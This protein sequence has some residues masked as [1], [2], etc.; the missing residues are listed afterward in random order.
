MCVLNFTKMKNVSKRM[1]ILLVVVLTVRS[2]S[3]QIKS[4]DDTG[5]KKVNGVEYKIVKNVPGENVKLGD[6]LQFHQ[7]LYVDT[8]VT[9]DS[10]ASGFIGSHCHKAE[11]WE[12][13]TEYTRAGGDTTETE[14]RTEYAYA[15]FDAILPF[16]SIGDSAIAQVA[17]DTLLSGEGHEFDEDSQSPYKGIMLKTSIVVVGFKSRDTYMKERKA[18]MD[19]AV[20]RSEEAVLGMQREEEER[21]ARAMHEGD[22]M[23]QQFFAAHKIQPR[24]TASGKF[25]IIE[26]KGIG[27]AIKE[28]DSVILKYTTSTLDGKIRVPG[29]SRE[30]AIKVGEAELGRD[31][32]EVLTLMQKGGEAIFYLPSSLVSDEVPKCVLK[33]SMKVVDEKMDDTLEAAKKGGNTVLQNKQHSDIKERESEKEAREKSHFEQM[34]L[35]ERFA[36]VMFENDGLLQASFA[37]RKIHPKKAD[38]GLYYILGKRGI[39]PNI[40]EG[41]VVMLKFTASTLDGKILEPKI[42][43]KG[44]KEV[45]VGQSEQLWPG[46]NEVLTMMQK[47]SEAVLYLP[48]K[49]VDGN[50]PNTVVKVSM[51]VLDVKADDKLK[52]SEKGDITVNDKGF[53]KVNG[54]EYKIVRDI[55]GK[56]A[57]EGESVDVHLFLSADTI[58]LSDTRV[59][60]ATVRLGIENVIDRGDWKAILPYLSTGDS[61]IANVSYDTLLFGWRERIPIEMREELPIQLPSWYKKGM[62]FHVSMTIVAI[63]SVNEVMKE[64]EEKSAENEREKQEAAARQMPEDDKI[65]QIYFIKNKIHPLK[66]ASG[67]YYTIEKKGTG[68]NIVNGQIV[69]IR[70]I[71]SVLNGL[72][73]DSNMDHTKEV[74]KITKGERQLIPGL[75]DALTLM[76]NG[77]EAIFYLPS[78][79]AYGSESPSNDIPPNSIM[80]FY[81]KVVDVQESKASR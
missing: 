16:L 70:Y 7:L 59:K 79:L 47:G 75:E 56:N 4:P 72:I 8:V 64:M 76:Q 23:L 51:K 53:K 26:K 61:V 50:L 20:R 6:Y 13:I 30:R 1:S 69:S 17:Y 48:S 65:L 80:R 57:E 24:K 22:A 63:K 10:R 34:F 77:S 49:F 41:Q 81:L 68:P 66:T 36:W 31:Y 32:Y 35:Q 9:D 37:E 78:P 29:T 62:T 3:A 46:I 67:L 54:V 43:M 18:I 2:S 40:R 38:A 5:F 19:D 11:P 60:G 33:T 39:G 55:P 12:F 14:I 58:V 42:N 27:P 28:G 52:E 73:F 15:H 44:E 45:T 25:F 74:H 71:G 21:Y